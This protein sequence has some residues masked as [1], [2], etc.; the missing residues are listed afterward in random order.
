MI[1][2]AGSTGFSSVKAIIEHA[3]ATGVN[4][5]FYLYWG[6]KSE[7]DLY[8]GLPR[9]WDKEYE[10]IDFRPVLTEPSSQWQGRSGF[11]HESVLI[12]FDTLIDYEVY[13]FGPLSMI[14]SII[15]TFFD[16]G[17]IKNNFFSDF[18]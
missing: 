6:V 16:H 15:D 2:I 9:K 8:M 3:I 17:L 14:K 10:N 13:S 5:K 11:V 18:S 1:L 4:R 12:D 7:V